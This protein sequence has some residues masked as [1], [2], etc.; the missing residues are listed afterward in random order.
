MPPNWFRCD[1]RIRLD[2]V[3]F[4]AKISLVGSKQHV[5]FS[6]PSWPLLGRVICINLLELP[7]AIRSADKEVQMGKAGEIA[8]LRNIGKDGVRHAANR[9]FSDVNCGQYLIDIGT[10][11]SLLPRPPARLLDLGCGTGWTSL[12]FAKA[13][14]EVVGVDIS[15][16][17]LDQAEQVQLNSGLENVSFRE[18]DYDE[19]LALQRAFQALKTGG[20][21]VTSEPGD[22]HQQSPHAVDA[23][24]R[25]GVTEKDMPPNKIAAL[26][27]EIGFRRFHFCPHSRQLT[28]V[29][30]EGLDQDSL[31]ERPLKLSPWRQACLWLVTRCFGM[32]SSDF[33]NLPSVMNYYFR[34]VHY[35][36]HYRQSGCLV[37]MVK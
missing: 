26:G 25:F 5:K 35:A 17:M 14:Y 37:R 19:R 2:R 29:L 22:G 13:G 33:P 24:R 20:V 3:D 12:M 15:S 34:L 6:H 18:C 4:R 31:D 27:S 23:V 30:F 21:C 32:R 1:C 28:G 10:V 7:R 16:D 8:Y 11:M 36:R 9:P